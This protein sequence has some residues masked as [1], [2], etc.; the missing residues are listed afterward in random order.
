MKH[1]DEDEKKILLTLPNVEEDD[2]EDKSYQEYLEKQKQK[3]QSKTS[4]KAAQGTFGALL[5]AKLNQGK[6]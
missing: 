6:K 5:A 3:S 2:E 4:D 1:I